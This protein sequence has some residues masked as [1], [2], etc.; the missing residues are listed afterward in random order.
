MIPEPF[1]L[2]GHLKLLL[3]LGA[4]GVVVA[5][6]L[7]RLRQARRKAA[8]RASRMTVVKKDEW[9]ERVDTP[10]AR[11]VPPKRV[12]RAA[13]VPAKKPR[14]ARPSKRQTVNTSPR[15]NARD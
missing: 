4:A 7:P 2:P 6:A 1:R 13:P 11:H 3:V 9:L 12:A 14:Q 5:L 15:I 10:V 8:S